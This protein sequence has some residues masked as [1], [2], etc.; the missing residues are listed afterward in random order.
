M[1][2]EFT[3]SKL[4]SHTHGPEAARKSFRLRWLSLSWGGCSS[5]RVPPASAGNARFSFPMNKLAANRRDSDRTPRAGATARPGSGLPRIS[6]VIRAHHSPF[7]LVTITLR[8]GSRSRP[9]TDHRHAPRPAT[10]A[11]L[12]RFE[13]NH[14]CAVRHGLGQR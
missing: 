2:M 1:N 4:R 12:S 10:S 3:V 9:E 6:S 7:S 8:I 13:Q 11:L 5:H 14:P